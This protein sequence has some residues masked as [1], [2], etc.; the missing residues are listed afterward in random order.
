MTVPIHILVANDLTIYHDLL[1]SV[2]PRLRPRLRITTAAPT[3]LEA[4]AMRLRPQLIICGR[5]Q[6]TLHHHAVV[7]AL[8]ADEQEVV[9]YR[10]GTYTTLPNPGL[11]DLLVVIDSA[12]A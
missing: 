1:A 4:V 7:L 2:L 11:A 9:V 5:P 12:A 8:S 6:V 10:D 3:E